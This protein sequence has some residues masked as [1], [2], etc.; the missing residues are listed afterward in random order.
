MPAAARPAR[1]A[2]ALALVAVL[3]LSACATAPQGPPG[4]APAV[5]VTPTPGD[6]FERWNR[7]VYAFNDALDNAV[8]KPVA[9]AYRAV[10]PALVRTGV[11]NVL[12]NFGDAWSS[13]NHLLQ[14]KVQSSLEMGMRVLVNTSFGLGGLLDPATEMRLERRSE[15]FGQTLGRW[16]VGTGPFLML[17][18]LGPS[19]LRDGLAWPVDRLGS[20]STLK[21]L[22]DAALVITGLE[23]LNTR[24]NLLQT[25]QLLDQVALDRYSFIR[26][27]Y[28]QRRLDQVYDGAPPMEDFADEPAE[29]PAPKPAAAAKVA[30]AA[31]P[32][33][34]SA[35]AA[36]PAA[37]SAP[38]AAP[39]PRP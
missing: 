11:D 26:D 5:V 8:V 21:S 23:L 14:G 24:T 22:D 4:A 25:T 37:A 12:G 32:A 28:Q 19:N 7:S 39:S 33:A 1:W 35:P 15:D 17:P 38:A 20:P 30:P 3:G 9:E 27:A 29:A 34:V 2:M 31:A 13:V 10:V 16:G 6:P 18:L 36:A